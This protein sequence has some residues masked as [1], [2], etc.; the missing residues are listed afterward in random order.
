MAFV[1]IGLG[2]NLGDRLKNIETA[3]DLL[4]AKNA[5]IIQCS[6]V[7]ETEPVGGPKQGKFLNA[8]VKIKTKLHPEDLLKQLKWIEKK[9]GKKKVVKNGPRTI[10]LDILLYDELRLETPQLTIPHPRVWQ[11]E[12][13]MKPLQDI[14]RDLPKSFLNAN[15]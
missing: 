4:R 8:V 15:N 2:S 1:Y 6:A 7:R 11:R 13:V 14:A 10:D 12:F 9:L 5:E 3:I